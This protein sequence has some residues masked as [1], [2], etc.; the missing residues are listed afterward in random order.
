MNLLP[1]QNGDYRCIVTDAN[2]CTDTSDIITVDD[3]LS[4]QEI[5]RSLTVNPNPFNNKTTI[6][7]NTN[8]RIKNILLFNYLGREI[9]NINYTITDNTII[10]NRKNIKI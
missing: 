2:G 7:L 10:F 3:L 1:I 4:T 8:D 9:K 5:Y 6:K